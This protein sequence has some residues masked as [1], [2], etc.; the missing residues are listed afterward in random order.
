VLSLGHLLPER[1]FTNMVI[2]NVLNI[3][4]LPMYVFVTER[5]EKNCLEI[6]KGERNS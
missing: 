6:V 4:I 3:E 2:T 1:D 5:P